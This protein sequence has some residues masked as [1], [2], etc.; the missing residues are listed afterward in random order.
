MSHDNEMF[1]FDNTSRLSDP[2][3]VMSTKMNQIELLSNTDKQFNDLGVVIVHTSPQ[4]IS[5]CVEECQ[6]SCPYNNKLFV[7]IHR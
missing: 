4:M 5:K 2:S 1:R 3:L 7:V 6:S